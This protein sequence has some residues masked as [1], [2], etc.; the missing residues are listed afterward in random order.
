MQPFSLED[1]G[2]LAVLAKV[3]ELRSFSAAARDLGLAKSAV[4]KRIASLERKLGV[5]LLVR[6]TRQVTLSEAGLRVYEHCAGVLASVRAA[7][8]ALRITEAGER[9]PVRV[10][11]PV[12]LAERTLTPLIRSFLDQHPGVEIRLSVADEM[13]DVTSGHHDLV[14][15]VARSVPERSLFARPLANDRLVL[16]ASPTYLQKYGEPKTPEDLVHHHCMRYLP[17]SAAVEW[18]FKGTEGPMVLNVPT[19]FSASDDASLRA[20]AVQGVGMAIMPRGFVARE[21]QSRELTLVLDGQ[22][23]HPER[24]IFAIV[25]EGRLAPPRVRRLVTYLASH[26]DPPG[27]GRLGSG[28]RSSGRESSVESR[29]T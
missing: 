17:R 27:R 1:V 4:S 8:A 16:V 6:T 24:T 20:A 14:I 12:L 11:A 3:V 25:P 18:R 19:R 9:G 22:L 7:G 29:T 13:V 26:M 28:A 23:W 2:S 5:R 10:N 21:L 15:R